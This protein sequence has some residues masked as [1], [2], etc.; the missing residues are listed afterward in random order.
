M[1]IAT[2]RQSERPIKN[3]IAV[4]A[5]GLSRG[6]IP[7]SDYV[8]YHERIENER[9]AKG[10]VELRQKADA[11]KRED[12][13]EAFN[14]KIAQFDTLSQQ[15]QEDWLIRARNE[16]PPALKSSKSALR[17]IAIELCYRGL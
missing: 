1:L 3:P 13:E 10:T 12:E 16:L 17:S 9:R 4:L 5:S 14:K 6:V 2:Y 11:E 15:D 8:P 7:P